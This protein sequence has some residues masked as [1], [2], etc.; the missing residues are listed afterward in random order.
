M[1]AKIKHNP[2]RIIIDKYNMSPTLLLEYISHYGG[3]FIS[4][5][6]NGAT[7][8]IKL[9]LTKQSIRPLL[10]YINNNLPSK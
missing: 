2:T 5:I 6:D 4:I 10:H 3:I 1:K 7:L 8:E 9:P